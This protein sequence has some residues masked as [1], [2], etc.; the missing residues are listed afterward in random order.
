MRSILLASDLTARSDRAF[1]RAAQLAEAHGAALTVLHVVDEDLLER[2][3]HDL[4]IEAE[5][6]LADQRAGLTGGQAQHVA[7]RVVSGKSDQTL[8]EEAEAVD[9]DLIVVGAHRP[10]R[11]A[12]FRGT[13]AERALRLGARPVLLVAN[14]VTR[15]Y[16]DIVAAVDFSLSA[17]LAL[18]TGLRLAPDARV[19]AV[20]AYHVPFS[21]FLGSALRTATRQAAAAR[22]RTLIETEMSALIETTPGGPGRVRSRLVE[23]GP[24]EAITRLCRE[25][26]PD[27]VVLGTHGR[28]GVSHAVLG[29][30]AEA[31][32]RNPPCDVLAVKAW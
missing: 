5:A 9:A 22:L 17:R 10:E 12:G 26:K 28:T 3:A 31:V 29:S 2:V 13:T 8:L 20:H 11:I 16:T 18:E 19:T 15:P 32:L 23:A 30:V 21:G 25:T 7:I 1:A 24:V 4:V 6:R 14:P 27:L